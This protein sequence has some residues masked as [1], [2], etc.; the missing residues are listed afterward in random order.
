M[1]TT[2]PMPIF[3]LAQKPANSLLCL[4]KRCEGLRV[5]P[6]RL[7]LALSPPSRQPRLEAGRAE[8]CHDVVEMRAVAGLDDELEQRALGRQVGE[9]SLM[10]DLDDVGAGFR[11]QR[12]HGG[13]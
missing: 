5:Q 4:V 13:E 12:R 10:R 7:R 3:T 8:L 1:A 6:G 9:G 2:R 11:Q